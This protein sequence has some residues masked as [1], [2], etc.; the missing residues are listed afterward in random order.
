M[1]LD[2]MTPRETAEFLRCSL[3]YVHKA[4]RAGQLPVHRLGT[5]Y[6]FIRT[7]LL[8]WLASNK[9][10]AQAPAPTR[11]DSTLQALTMAAP[12]DKPVN[13]SRPGPAKYAGVRAQRKLEALRALREHGTI[14]AAA[15]AAG[16][17]SQSISNWRKQDP[18]FDARVIEIQQAPAPAPID[19]DT[20]FTLD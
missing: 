14:K 19:S 16:V 15:Q 13:P 9:P 5:D 4:A 2:V 7:E 18:Q 10:A 12:E 6:R 20:L 3:S 11:Q 8:E 17:S 1:Q